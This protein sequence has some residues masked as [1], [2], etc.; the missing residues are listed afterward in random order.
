MIYGMTKDKALGP[1]EFFMTFYHDYWDVFGKHILK[2]L[3]DF[4]LLINLRKMLMRHLLILSLTKLGS[5]GEG[6]LAY[7]SY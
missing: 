1:D 2:I 6:F 5:R 4:T 3:Q 7:H